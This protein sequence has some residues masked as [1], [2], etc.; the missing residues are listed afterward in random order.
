MDR[1][2][3]RSE[4]RKIPVSG[5]VPITLGSIGAPP[6][7]GVWT[8]E[9]TSSW[10]S[11]TGRDSRGAAAG[12][13]GPSSQSAEDQTGFVYPVAP[14][15]RPFAVVYGHLGLD[16]R[17]DLGLIDRATGERQH[18]IRVAAVPSSQ[19][20]SWCTRSARRFRRFR[21][22][23]TFVTSGAS[24]PVVHD[25]MAFAAAAANL[26]CLPTV[27]WSTNPRVRDAVF[28]GR[29]CGSISR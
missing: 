3:T 21:S 4:L 14:S 29:S 5:G 15:Q 19:M 28:R 9:E 11:P 12:A 1:F 25:V 18:L 16:D 23:G 8:K 13:K 7:G 2:F 17:P 22:T 20:G 26:R 6:R 27:R 10:R 24:F